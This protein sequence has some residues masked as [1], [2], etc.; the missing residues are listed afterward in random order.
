MALHATPKHLLSRLVGGVCGGSGSASTFSNS[1][2][3]CVSGADSTGLPG[4][5]IDHLDRV[6]VLGADGRLIHG[7]CSPWL[8][9]RHTLR[10]FELPLV[11]G[12]WRLPVAAQRSLGGGGVPSQEGRCSP[13]FRCGVHAGCCAVQSWANL[14][15]VAR[16]LHCL[17][18]VALP[19]T[20]SLVFRQLEV[21][22][23][24]LFAM[25]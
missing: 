14:I 25:T 11:V 15:R 20:Q 8:A 19:L 13:M 1:Y 12:Q 21:S 18:E 24:R 10:V 9:L 4:R 6:C 22:I 7:F 5:V 23:Q 3:S 16:L 2:P 17:L